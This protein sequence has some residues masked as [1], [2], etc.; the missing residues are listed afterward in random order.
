M[1]WFSA[2]S[3]PYIVTPLEDVHIPRTHVQ[4]ALDEIDYE[5]EG[6]CQ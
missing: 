4:E 5:E 3:H 6:D 1:R 2:I